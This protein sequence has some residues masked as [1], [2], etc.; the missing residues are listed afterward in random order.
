MCTYARFQLD[1]SARD[2]KRTHAHDTS[3]KCSGRV[4]S[5]A[6]PCAAS[7]GSSEVLRH[8]GRG[9]VGRRLLRRE[10]QL[11]WLPRISVRRGVEPFRGSDEQFL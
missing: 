3:F 11:R 9:R 6:C 8:L 4:S 7:S 1:A 2:C 5:L 10:A